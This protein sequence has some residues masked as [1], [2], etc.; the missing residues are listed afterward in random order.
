LEVVI[1]AARYYGELDLFS[2]YCF[3]Y[4]GTRVCQIAGCFSSTG[5]THLQASTHR[6]AQLPFYW[7]IP[8]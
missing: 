8:G 5:V 1:I 7:R 3:L 6:A 4:L 2:F